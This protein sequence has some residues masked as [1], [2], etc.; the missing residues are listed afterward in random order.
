MHTDAETRLGGKVSVRRDEQT[1]GVC[2]F[3]ICCKNIGAALVCPAWSPGRTAVG[4]VAG[5][6][7]ATPHTR[8]VASER[9]R[10][11]AEDGGLEEEEEEREIVS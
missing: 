1:V 4:H 9:E 6:G 2:G 10:D 5:V 3:S 11:L 7:A 8:G